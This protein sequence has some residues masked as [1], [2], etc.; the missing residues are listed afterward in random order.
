MELDDKDGLSFI[1]QLDELLGMKQYCTEC[2]RKLRGWS[3]WDDDSRCINQC[4][5]MHGKELKD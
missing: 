5:I 4:C 2:G 1:S 3:Y